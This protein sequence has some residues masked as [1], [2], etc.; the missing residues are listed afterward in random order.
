M[1]KFTN[2]EKLVIDE[3]WEIIESELFDVVGRID[4]KY[5][6]HFEVTCFEQSFKVHEKLKVNHFEVY[7]YFRQK[8]QNATDSNIQFEYSIMHKSFIM[9]IYYLQA[10]LK[11]ENN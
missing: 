3:N 1:S 5:N 11:P 8:V 9:G 7:K 2:E 6:G 10:A 4:P